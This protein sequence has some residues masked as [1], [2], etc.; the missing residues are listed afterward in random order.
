MYDAY[1]LTFMRPLAAAANDVG[2]RNSR[3]AVFRWRARWRTCVCILGARCCC[4][5]IALK[6]LPCLGRKQTASGE[7]I[8]ITLLADTRHLLNCR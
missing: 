3:Y 5:Q 6:H 8:R 1:L 2:L 4:M 7:K